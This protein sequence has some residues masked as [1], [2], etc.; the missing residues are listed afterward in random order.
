MHIFK[1]VFLF[2]LPML[3]IA[4]NDNDYFVTIYNKKQF[5]MHRT[6]LKLTIEPYSK[7]IYDFT[8]E[9]YDFSVKCDDIL[10]V[11]HK[12]NIVCN[13]PYST[14][15]SYSSFLELTLSHKNKTY[16]SVYKDLKNDKNLL[17]EIEKM[18]KYV[19]M[20]H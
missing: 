3:F 20:S 4:C 17:A 15:K 10:K 16:Y 1:Q 13:S 7:N 12:S 14:N 5:K 11:R 2:F 9:L 18:L 6:C 8:S 19:L